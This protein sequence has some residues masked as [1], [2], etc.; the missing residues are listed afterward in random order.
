V[1]KSREKERIIKEMPNLLT[2]M[3]AIPLLQ[4]ERGHD[5]EAIENSRRG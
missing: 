3:Q 2:L 1:V 5:P 4:P